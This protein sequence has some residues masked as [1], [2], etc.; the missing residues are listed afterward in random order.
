MSYRIL[1][2][3]ELRGV[4][5]RALQFLYNLVHSLLIVYCSKTN[6]TFL[7]CMSSPM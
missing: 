5:D 6:L 7:I 3:L 1:Q 2:A 4:V